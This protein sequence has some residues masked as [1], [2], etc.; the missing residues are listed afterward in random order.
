MLSFLK[1]GCGKSSLIRNLCSII[2]AVLRTLNIHGGMDDATIV[3]WM[4]REAARAGATRERIVVFLDEVNT[5]N[6]MGLF[7]EIV[8]DR[9]LNGVPLPSNM[10]IIAA[11][12]PYRLRSTKAS[13]YGGEE[14]AGL[15]YEHH[16][17]R[18]SDH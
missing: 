3:A 7:K 18:Q 17:N 1:T 9:C 5:C 11:C 15:A 13:L 14:M 8:V 12:N 2:G 4:Q 16:G 6:C 10:A